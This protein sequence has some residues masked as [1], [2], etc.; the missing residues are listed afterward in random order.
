M[1]LEEVVHLDGYA[2]NSNTNERMERDEG[3]RR[4]HWIEEELK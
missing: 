4:G 3:Y 1:T 2:P